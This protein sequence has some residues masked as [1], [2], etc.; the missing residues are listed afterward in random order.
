[1]KYRSTIPSPVTCI[2]VNI[3]SGIHYKGK[4]GI[5]VNYSE[6]TFASYDEFCIWKKDEEQTAHTYF[7]QHGG[8]VVKEPYS[9]LL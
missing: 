4:H 8:V 9:L 1:M 2:F 7:V 5:I 6:H 3:S